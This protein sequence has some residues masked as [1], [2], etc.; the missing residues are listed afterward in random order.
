MDPVA[1]N[2]NDWVALLREEVRATNCTLAARKIGYSR[3][4]VSLALA[5]KYPG[6]TD[7]IRA[8]VL[9]CLHVRCPHLSRDIR[10]AECFDY[11]D[12]PLPTGSPQALRHWRA[13]RACPNRKN[14]NAKEE[15]SP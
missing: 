4:A 2:D 12:R 15:T 14:D 3:S 6:G 10:Q 7:R 8:A 11:Q 1:V 13:C 9:A 5:G